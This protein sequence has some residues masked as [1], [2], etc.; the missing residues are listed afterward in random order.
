MHMYIYL[1]VKKEEEDG[2]GDGSYDV[3]EERGW[4]KA[5]YYTEGFIFESLTEANKLRVRPQKSTEGREHHDTVFISLFIYY[6][7][8]EVFGFYARGDSL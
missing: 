8:H 2:G 3:T 5:K 7:Y 1:S 4:Q 6:Y